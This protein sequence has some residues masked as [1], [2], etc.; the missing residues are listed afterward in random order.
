MKYKS[1]VFLAERRAEL[2]AIPDLLEMSST[3]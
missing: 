3:A 2:K 1:G